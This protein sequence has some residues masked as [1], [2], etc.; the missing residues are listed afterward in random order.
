[1]RGFVLGWLV[2]VAALAGCARKTPAPGA[3]PDSTQAESTLARALP[4]RPDSKQDSIALEGMEL[5][6]RFRLYDS[7]PAG[8]GVPFTT[9]VPE[10]MAVRWAPAESGD[11]FVARAVFGG[12]VEPRAYVEV[13]FLPAGATEAAAL[14]SLSRWAPDERPSPIE[15]ERR[16]AWSIA[17]RWTARGAGDQ[18][19][20]GIAALGR[21]GARLFVVRIEYPAEYGEGLLPRVGKVLEDWRWEDTGGGLGA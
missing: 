18:E 6:L 19:V 10:D 1:M 2:T 21:H 17:E 13:R 5:S 9:Y 3:G 14:D 8:L 7:R 20:D 11:R 4:P 15:G 12:K 16:Y